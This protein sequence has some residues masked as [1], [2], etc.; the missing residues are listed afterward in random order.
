MTD[1][2]LLEYIFF[3]RPPCDQFKQY[4][5]RIGVEMLKEGIDETDVEAFTVYV[6]DELDDDISEQIE[7]F[8][9]QMMELDESLVIAHDDND[10]YSQ[11]GLAVT[12]NDGRSVMASVD[13]DVLNRVLTVISHDE[14]GKLV[15]VI[16]DA[17][18]NPDERPLCKRDSEPVEAEAV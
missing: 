16:V 10:E 9:D 17:V 1:E 18:E 12:L 14:L 7:A 13:P 8:Y 3:N 15:D 6:S 4:L 5:Q 2:L 11:V